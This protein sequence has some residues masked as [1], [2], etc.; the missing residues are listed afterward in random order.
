M[1]DF[2]IISVIYL[3]LHGFIV[4]LLAQ[5][6]EHCAGIAEVMCPNLFSGFISVTAQLVFITVNIAFVF[7][8]LLILLN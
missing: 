4:G 7:T 8:S 5:L 2:H 6:V 1:Y 3:S